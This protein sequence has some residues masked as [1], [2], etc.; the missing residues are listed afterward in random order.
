MNDI[1]R[2]CVFILKCVVPNFLIKMCRVT[3]DCLPS[4]WLTMITYCCCL[5][6][7]SHYSRGTSHF[8]FILLMS[9]WHVLCTDVHVLLTIVVSLLLLM[10]IVSVSE[11]LY[12]VY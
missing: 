4:S 7:I 12:A 6:K 3:R 9:F 8:Y 5:I 11:V 2:S 10:I 1:V